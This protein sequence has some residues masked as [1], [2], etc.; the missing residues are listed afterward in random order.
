MRIGL[1]IDWHPMSI[2][3]VQ[4]HVKYLSMWLEKKGFE[5]VII[6]RRIGLRGDSDE[7]DSFNVIVNSVVP[8]ESLVIPPDPASLREAIVKGGFDV[9]HSHHI[10][11]LLPLMAL[12]IASELDITRVATNH[13]LFFLYDSKVW[14]A[15]SYFIPT[16][17]YLRYAQAIISVSGEAK[18]FVDS[19]MGGEHTYRHY[20]IPNGVDTE[21]YTPPRREPSSNRVIFVGRLVHRKGV[22][23]LVNS[24][25]LI[26]R[27]IPDLEVVIVG[28]GYM[29]MF[30]ELQARVL[31][32]VDKVKLLGRLPESEKIEAL[33]SSKIAVVPSI[34]NECFGITA[35]EAMATG[36]PVIASRVGGLK[37]VVEDGVTGILVSPGSERE[38]AEAVIT[39]LQDENTRRRMGEKAR[40]VVEKK[41][42]WDIVVDE[43]IRVYR[44][45]ASEVKR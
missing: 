43:I 1:V 3:G 21:K 38:L 40:E 9:I 22:H 2:G 26:L 29:R 45:V 4:S 13:T 31:G 16:R 28:D 18:K 23:V 20:V 10:F 42:S 32:I 41:F 14:S 37:E 5:T 7:L 11:T 44:E 39:L 34:Y 19:I 24:I 36:R 15:I 12:K 8:L 35:I 27:E 25:P 30:V 33:R 6:S 17:Y